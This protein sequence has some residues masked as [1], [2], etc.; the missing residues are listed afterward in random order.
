MRNFVKKIQLDVM[1][2]TLKWMYL[3]LCLS[4]NK[5]YRDIMN[6]IQSQYEEMTERYKN[7]A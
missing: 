6:S 7:S 5:Q 2:Q 1:E 4:E 3:L